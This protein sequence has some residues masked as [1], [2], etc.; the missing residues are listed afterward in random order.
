[1]TMDQMIEVDRLMVE[2]LHIDLIQMMENAGR[3]LAH[4]ARQL[5]LG[6]DATAAQVVTLA[7]PGGNGGGALVAARRLH[8][9]G[10]DVRV[11]LT[12]RPDA[13]KAV[14]AHQL[15]SLV[16]IG[17]PVT[18]AEMVSEI[19]RADLVLDGILGY[20]LEGPPRGAAAQLIG[21]ANGR[22][23]PILALDL[24]SGLDATKGPV[25]R[26]VIVATATLTLAL[27]KEGL[28]RPGAE[29]YVGDLYLADIGVPPSLYRRLGLGPAVD[30]LFAR[31][32]ILR[33]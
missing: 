18:H 8:A 7:G 9:W 14:T 32:D 20:R 2:D 17:V 12:T 5:F 10:G 28:R 11:V 26:P 23:T 16:R 24:P 6:G 4:L 21:W 3:A 30:P 19:P 13:L 29:R 27:P 1:V 31:D 33:L 22:G 25:F 15:D